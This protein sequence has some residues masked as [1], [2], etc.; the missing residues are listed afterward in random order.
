[1]SEYRWG[2]LGTGAIAHKFAHDLK[3][4]PG[5]ILHSVHSRTFEKAG[6]FADNFGFHTNHKDLKSFLDDP[7]LDIVY[8]SSP[9]HL[10]CRQAIQCLEAGKHVLVEKPMALNV[11][12]GEEIVVAANKTG[13]FCME[14]MWS[15]F[16]PVYLAVKELIGNGVIGEVKFMTGDF[17]FKLHYSPDQYRFSLASGGGS[18]MDV[19]VYP[20]SLALMLLGDP[21]RVEGICRKGPSGVDT[22]ERI[23]MYYKNGAVADIRSAFDCQLSNGIWVGG[24]KGAIE[25]PGPIYSP[26][27]YYLN[28]YALPGSASAVTPGRLAKVRRIRALSGPLAFLLDD[29]A[30]PL[31]RM[32]SAAR[33]PH[34][35]FGYQ[36]E[37]MEAMRSIDLGNRES[38]VM[39]LSETLAVLEI[40]DALRRDWGISFPG[41]DD[42]AEEA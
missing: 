35:F 10:H 6:A 1:M 42:P 12:E 39:P 14:A 9:N 2:I 29:I 16:I 38:L 11:K 21:E 13:R 41:I 24:D 37:A 19:G 15:R 33:L 30:A 34:E 3:T 36:Y 28:K 22:M 20:I 26:S 31:R 25:I 40:T 4:V 17:G 18:L 5:A 32:R 7:Q 8:I 23:S 27:R